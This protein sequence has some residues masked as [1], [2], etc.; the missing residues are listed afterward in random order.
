MGGGSAGVLVSPRC[1]RT[2]PNPVLVNPA[3]RHMPQPEPSR[4]DRAPDRQDAE[5]AGSVR[6]RLELV[7][8]VLGELDLL[9]QRQ[10]L[11]VRTALQEEEEVHE[12]QLDSEENIMVL[13]G[14]ESRQ[15]RVEEG[16]QNIK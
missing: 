4:R 16:I 2:P 3:E 1:S 9:R 15:N 14:K 10:E 6:D 7:G 11:L 13:V 12:A 8:L 5:R